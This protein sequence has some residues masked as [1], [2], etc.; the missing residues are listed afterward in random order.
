MEK[1]FN[2]FSLEGKNIIVTGASSGIGQQIAIVCSRMG[3]KITLIGRNLERLEVTK[4]QLE[5]EEHL[6]LCYDLTDFE[7]QKELIINIVAKMGPIDGLVNCAGISTTMPFKLLS[8]E[9]LDEY[10]KTN[11]YASIELTRQ[12]LNI[13]NVKSFKTTTNFKP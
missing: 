3:A 9:K 6:L 13:K 11:V 2:P 12:A 8:P 4:S 10:F 7:H 5:G 1:Q